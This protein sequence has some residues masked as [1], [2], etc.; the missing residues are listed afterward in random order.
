M[1]TRN[2]ESVIQEAEHGVLE[3]L[4]TFEDIQN[5]MRTERLAEFQA[6]LRE[7]A[8]DGL[9]ELTDRFTRILFASFTTRFWPVSGTAPTLGGHS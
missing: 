1:A 3:F 4:R 5:N 6:Q 8:P 7:E 9:T 2:Y